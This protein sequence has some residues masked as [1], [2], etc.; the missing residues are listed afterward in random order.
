MVWIVSEDNSKHYLK[1]FDPDGTE[2]PN[3]EAMAGRGLVFTRAFSNAP[4]CSVARTTLATGCHAPRI[5]TLNHR[6]LEPARLPAGLRLF[7]GLLRAAGYYTTNQSKEDFNT[8]K[9]A[10]A[11]D[12][13]SKTANWRSRPDPAQPFFHMESHAESHESS[14]HFPADAVTTEPTM[15]AASTQWKTR[16][17]RS[18]TR[19]GMWGVFIGQ[20]LLAS[21][22]RGGGARRPAPWC[23]HTAKWPPRPARAPVP[24]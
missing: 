19:T 15:L 20:L 6:R 14:L 13:S 24:A 17:G 21:R 7:S 12:E 11:W 4:V 23:N 2:T 9:D 5:A 8:A 1:L 10:E 18:Q 22:A 16:V 3:I